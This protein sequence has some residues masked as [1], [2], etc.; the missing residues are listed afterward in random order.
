MFGFRNRRRRRNL[1]TRPF[2]ASCRRTLEEKFPLFTQLPATDQRELEGHIQVFVAE[3]RFEGCG[4]F[5][6]T[7]EVRVLIAAPACLLIL[8]RD[9]VLDQYGAEHPA[10]FFA[11]AMEC[12]FEKPRQLQRRHPKLCDELKQFYRQDPVT[13]ALPAGSE[14]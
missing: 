7:D 3:K 12:F 2:P 5:Q 13:F 9:T 6:I 1:R 4:G 11:V 14:S 8:H 10:E